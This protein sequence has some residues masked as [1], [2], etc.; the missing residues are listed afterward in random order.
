[1]L[2]DQWNQIVYCRL[3]LNEVQPNNREVAALRCWA[4]QAQHRPTFNGFEM[5]LNAYESLSLSSSHIA[6]NIAKVQANPVPKIQE[7]YHIYKLLIG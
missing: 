6:F 2:Y 1:M 7:K 4:S 3:V 5:V